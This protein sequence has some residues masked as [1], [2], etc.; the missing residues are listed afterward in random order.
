MRLFSDTARV[1]ALNALAK[2]A[3]ALKVVVIARYF[4]TSADLDAFLIAF[5]LPAFLA[6]VV[7]GCITPSLVPV[8]VRTRADR[9]DG[10]IGEIASSAAV[11]CGASLALLGLLLAVGAPA[12]LRILASGFSP[13]KLDLSASLFCLLLP[14]LP[15]SGFINVWRAVLNARGSFA[16]PAIATSATPLML[17]AATP[18]LAGRIGA[19]ALC[20][21]TLLGMLTEAAILTIAVRRLGYALFSRPPRWL[22]ELRA[23][24]TQYIPLAAGV[25][26]SSACVIVDQAMASMLGAGSVATL[27]YGS[28]L[29]TVGLGI[30]AGAL[31]SVS[32]PT[33]SHLAANGNWH[34]LR[35][36]ASQL[37]GGVFLFSI[38]ATLLLMLVSEPLVRFAFERGAFDTNATAAVA[39]VQT[40]ALLQ[41]PFSIA[42]ALMIRLCVAVQAS[43]LIANVAVGGFLLNAVGNIFLSRW[44][45]LAGI[46][47]STAVAQALALAALLVLLPRRERRLVD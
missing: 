4:G 30:A 41:V 19:L 8:L 38:P 23:A 16:L 29:V 33:F 21:G 43:S 2:L 27:D 42:L 18:L 31:G 34:R 9:G 28:K 26:I 46:A 40:I 17:V 35:T 24:A 14:G 1:G 45:G 12:I 37:L 32:L 15:L 22:P 36:T 47:L 25:M 11:L 3:G 13:S 6:D 10:E 39:H 5:L 44:L 7:A 20:A